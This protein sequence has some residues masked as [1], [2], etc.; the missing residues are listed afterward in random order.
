M[1]QASTGGTISSKYRAKSCGRGQKVVH[2]VEQ[3]IYWAQS[4]S[5]RSQTNKSTISCMRLVDS[6]SILVAELLYDLFDPVKVFACSKISDDSFKT[7]IPL[8][9]FV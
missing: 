1:K 9:I 6:I 4:D 3:D 5:S 8:A 7:A 2:I